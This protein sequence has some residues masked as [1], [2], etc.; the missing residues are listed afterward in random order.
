MSGN[1]NG[2]ETVCCQRRE[3][4]GEGA[5]ERERKLLCAAIQWRE[6]KRHIKALK[7]N[8]KNI[9]MSFMDFLYRS[10]MFDMYN[11]LHS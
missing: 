2:V 6:H 7:I 1:R 11:L 5:R 3:A 10:K 4:E 8:I 9:N